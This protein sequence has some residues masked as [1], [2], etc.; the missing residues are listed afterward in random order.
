MNTEWIVIEISAPAAAVDLLCATLA[1]LGSGGTVVEE[2]Q[3]DTFIPPQP[4]LDPDATYRLKTYFE[5]PCAPP[6]LI[7]EIETA[8]ERISALNPTWSFEVGSP[9]AVRQEDW[10]ENWKQNFSTLRIGRRLVIKPTWEEHPPQPEE[11]IIEIDPGMAFG[12]GTHATTL[13]CLETLAELFDTKTPPASLLDVGTGSGILALAAA[14]LGCERVLACDI[15][16]E[17][18]RVAQQ[19][20]DHN[21]YQEQIEITSRPLEELNGRFDLVIANI[22]AEENF[23]LG[24]LLCDRLTPGGKLILSGILREKEDYVRAGFARY[25]LSSAPTRYHEDWICL[26]YQKRGR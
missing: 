18:C 16:P 20:V 19:N 5:Q 11:R 24:Q 10:A 17:A 2:R 1:D 7:R 26:V 13:L 12:T 22:L 15:D 6:Q 14:A 4:E 3:L 8:L 9:A 21:R 25:P 23:R